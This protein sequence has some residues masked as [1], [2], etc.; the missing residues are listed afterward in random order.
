MMYESSHRKYQ[1]LSLKPFL[2]LCV[3]NIEEIYSDDDDD[4]VEDSHLSLPK[5][6]TPAPTDHIPLL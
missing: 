2:R 1:F 3:C 6:I 5:S 4:G